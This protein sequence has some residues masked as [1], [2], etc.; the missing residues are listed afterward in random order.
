MVSLT[1]AVLLK[2][3]IRKIIPGGAGEM[4][5]NVMFDLMRV[6]F[7]CLNILVSQ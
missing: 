3:I 2:I 4:D 7:Y 5:F 6:D 1:A